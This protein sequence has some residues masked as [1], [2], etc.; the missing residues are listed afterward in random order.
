MTK[1]ALLATTAVFNSVADSKPQ[2]PSPVA[3]T[4][5]QSAVRAHKLP[6]RRPR[7]RQKRDTGSDDDSDD[8]DSDPPARADKIYL[9]AVQLRK[10]WGNCSHMFVERLLKS[11]PNMPRPVKLGARI[12]FFDL[13]AIERY[14]RSK[15]HAGNDAV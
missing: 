8:D 5:Q 12:R 4:R 6:P 1:T 11:D 15:I 13:D 7:K 3:A 2:T 14:E 10:R 9:T